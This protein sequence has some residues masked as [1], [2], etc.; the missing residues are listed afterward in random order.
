MQG[1]TLTTN[2]SEALK[3]LEQAILKGFKDFNHIEKDKDFEWLRTDP[4]FLSLISKYKKK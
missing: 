1:Y 4:D 3:Y 2:K